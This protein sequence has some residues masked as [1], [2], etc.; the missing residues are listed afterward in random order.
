VTD[1]TAILDS[2]TSFGMLTSLLLYLRG[3]CSANVINVGVDLARAASARLRG[4]TLVDTRRSLEACHSESAVYA[5]IAQQRQAMIEQRH[6]RLR[7]D[8]SAACL[9]A[10]LDFD[11]RR[12]AGDPFKILPRESQFHDL[13]VTSLGRGTKRLRAD[14]ER[15]GRELLR[16]LQAGMRPLI[17]VPS[18]KRQLERVLLVYDGSEAS[19]QAIRSYLDLDPIP[20]AEL[21]LLAIGPNEDAARHSLR[22]MADYCSARRKRF[23]TGCVRGSLRRILA[24]YAGRWQA[25]LVVLGVDRRRGLLPML[26]SPCDWGGLAQQGCGVFLH[27]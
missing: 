13:V 1:V 20:A 15:R 14:A 3:S 18:D 11:L 17:V 6:V 22:D 26:S 5:D 9:E 19:G 12:V 8:L 10:D 7:R 23:E 4:L 25:D 2:E 16:L 21:R 27:G 24:P